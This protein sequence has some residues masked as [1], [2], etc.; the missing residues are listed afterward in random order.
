[1]NTYSQI[2]KNSPLAQDLTSLRDALA[3][4]TISAEEA[5]K[6]CLLRIENTDKELNALISLNAHALEEARALDKE[7]YDPKKALWGVPIAIK[8]C[9][10]TKGQPTR[11]CSKILNDFIPFYDAHVVEALKEAGAII[12]GKANMDEFAMGS[13]T[14]NSAY[15][16]SHNP[17]DTSRIPGGSSGGS[18]VTVA[19]YQV[20]GALGSDTGGSIRQPAALCGCVGLKPTYGAVSRYGLIAYGSSLDQIGPLTRS[21]RD[22]ALLFDCIAGPDQRDT[23][24]NPQA[25]KATFTQITEKKDLT[26]TK[27]GIVENLEGLDPAVQA[28]YQANIE[29]AKKLG[30]SLVPI[31]LPYANEHAIATYYIIAMAEASS[32]LARFDGVRYGKRTEQPEQLEDL[33]VR[34]R[35]EGFGEEVQR[36]ILLGTYVLSSGYYDAYYKKAAQ[37]RRLIQEDFLKAFEACDAILSPVSP[38]PAW[39]HGT[40]LDNPLQMYLLDIFTVSVNLAG[41]PAV[42]YP[43][44]M[45]EHLPVG[46]QLIGAAFDEGTILRIANCLH[47]E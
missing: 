44:G 43:A 11:A 19:S 38:V 15:G 41:L 23:T 16:P 47:T 6:A 13:T 30:A 45:A 46:L 42:S 1:M 36:R 18:A 21:V 4:G 9:I 27:I 35:S 39:P 40:N 2:D 32:N 31:S 22:A 25:H 8:D 20:F 14:E 29:K 33:Y 5:C 28:V 17:H 24:S 3:Q 7:G 10:A 26:G 34:S 37:V 12:I